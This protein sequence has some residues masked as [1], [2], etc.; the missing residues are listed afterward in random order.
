MALESEDHI[1]LQTDDMLILLDERL[2]PYV[3]R[4][5]HLL[6]FSTHHCLKMRNQNKKDGSYLESGFNET[7]NDRQGYS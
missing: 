3:Y 2:I 7:A 6:A 4:G 5:S 1:N